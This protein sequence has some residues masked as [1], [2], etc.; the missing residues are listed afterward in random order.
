MLYTNGFIIQQRT[1]NPYKGVDG[2]GFSENTG[3]NWYLNYS[4]AC[5]SRFE[6]YYEE[7]IERTYWNIEP[8]TW[9]GACTDMDYIRRYI[10]V[11][12]ELGIEYRLL[13]VRTEIPA[14]VI[15]GEIGLKTTFLGYDY[16]YESGDYYS[17]VY[18]EI[19]FVFPQFALNENGLFQTEKEIREYISQREKFV[20]THTP[21]TLESGD[22]VV[23]E[24]HE[25][26]YDTL[27]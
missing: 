18:N 19:P 20:Q 8:H 3:Q 6:P 22:F 11:S 5:Q 14:P 23:Y 25:V 10:A 1:D 26:D 15:E 2:S 27:D 12:K 21:N 7:H 13:L 4:D 16:A 24:V 17:A 9:V